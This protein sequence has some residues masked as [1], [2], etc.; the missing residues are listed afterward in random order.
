M[1]SAFM[2]AIH[3]EHSCRKVVLPKQECL[4][5][6]IFY[7]ASS[8]DSSTTEADSTRLLLPLLLVNIR[9]LNP[10]VDPNEDIT[11][12]T[13]ARKTIDDVMKD[14][15]SVMQQRKPISQDDFMT[16]EDLDLMLNNE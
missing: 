12:A 9:H 11:N 13:Q 6:Y 5:A 2:L 7:I 3:P 14:F 1:A 15:H 10:F 8:H 16:D 4:Y